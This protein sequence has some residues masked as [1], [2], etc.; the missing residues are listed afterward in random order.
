R[1]RIRGVCGGDRSV[2]AARATRQLLDEERT[3]YRFARDR[4]GSVL[5]GGIGAAE[6]RQRQ[7]V[8][9][10]ELEWAHYEVSHLGTLGP[11][12]SRLH[13]KWAGLGFG[14]T[15]RHHEKQGRFSRWADHL[16]KQRRAVE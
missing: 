11:V 8:R 16:E 6:Q 3:S 9:A 4:G 1:G 7:A 5:R 2:N 14:F 13:E 10:L 15:I 12:C